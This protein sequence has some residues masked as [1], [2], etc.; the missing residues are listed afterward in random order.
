M[1]NRKCPALV[2]GKLCDLA[3]ILIEREVETAID[4]Y[5]CPRGHRKYVLLGEIVK[6]QCPAL[7]NG[8]ACGLA[9]TLV[10]RELEAATGVYEC[11]LS[12]RTYVPLKRE[13]VD[14]S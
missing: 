5:E 4:V 2:D 13:A 7:V 10:N 12:H 6:R 1:E 14:S 11:P 3:L 9:L 8:K